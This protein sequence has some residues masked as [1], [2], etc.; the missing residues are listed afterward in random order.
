MNIEDKLDH[1]WQ[2]VFCA[3]MAALIMRGHN[4]DQIAVLAGQFADAACK[5]YRERTI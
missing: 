2:Q 4:P 5:E 3:A 1:L